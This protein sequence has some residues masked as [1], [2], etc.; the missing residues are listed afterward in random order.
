MS[1]KKKNN[2]G[3]NLLIVGGVLV[4]GFFAFRALAQSGFWEKVLSGM[5]GGEENWLLGD[6]F[7]ERDELPL[8]GPKPLITAPR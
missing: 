2:T 6:F 3:R 8:F 4:G 1:E 5:G 7:G